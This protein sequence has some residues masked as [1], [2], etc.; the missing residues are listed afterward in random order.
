MKN[1]INKLEVKSLKDGIRICYDEL[2][3]TAPDEETV[4]EILEIVQT[5][6]DFPN[7][8]FDDIKIGT[9]NYINMVLAE[10]AEPINE[11]I[12]ELAKKGLG[13]YKNA[14]DYCIG[15]IASSADTM[16]EAIE[17]LIKLKE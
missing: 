17:E 15:E 5:D 13:E 4:E 12:L 1:T 9:R 11:S 16:A 10:K 8:N 14:G 7:H 2:L 6:S 3:D